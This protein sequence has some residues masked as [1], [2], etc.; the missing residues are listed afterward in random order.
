MACT[1]ELDA[2]FERRLSEPNAFYHGYFFEDK[3]EGRPR[4]SRN[5]IAIDMFCRPVGDHGLAEMRAGGL[6]GLRQD[7]VDYHQPQPGDR[8]PKEEN[9][10]EDRLEEMEINVD[11]LSEVQK[12]DLGKVVL[13][14]RERVNAGQKE[15]LHANQE[16]NGQKD[17][18]SLNLSLF[19]CGEVNDDDYNGDVSAMEETMERDCQEVE[20]DWLRLVTAALR[21]LKGMKA[22]DVTR[23]TSTPMKAK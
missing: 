19:K 16:S 13:D 7:V 21:P 15:E 11:D 23:M 18:S 20:Y 12:R 10:E 22:N 8:P 3:V 5:V 1:F 9:N 17:E 4:Q 6:N 2:E 14:R